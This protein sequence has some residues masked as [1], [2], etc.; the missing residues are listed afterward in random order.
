MIEDASET[1]GANMER[2]SNSGISRILGK[3]SSSGLP[4]GVEGE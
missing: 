3:I 1:G 4:T 2:F